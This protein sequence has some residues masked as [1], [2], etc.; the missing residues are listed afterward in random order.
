MAR[1]RGRWGARR[2][3]G[4]CAYFNRLQ[5]DRDARVRQELDGLSDRLREAE[6]AVLELKATAARAEAEGEER[7][8]Q[9]KAAEEG[10][11]GRLQAATAAWKEEAA[12]LE[13]R[14]REAES[15][16][17]AARA[18]ATAAMA[19]AATEAERKLQQ[20]QVTAA[21]GA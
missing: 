12:A 21:E 5:H 16:A 9:A 14:V 6:R 13:A 7:L 19:E 1:R 10:A 17:D 4:L 11:E 15:R 2:R 20:A 18:D 3:A 8:R